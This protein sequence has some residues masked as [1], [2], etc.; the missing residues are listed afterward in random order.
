MIL[1]LV[2]SYFLRVTSFSLRVA[3]WMNFM[4]ENRM[5]AVCLS[6]TMEL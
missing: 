5:Q 1:L 2:A 6:V 3:S 4:P